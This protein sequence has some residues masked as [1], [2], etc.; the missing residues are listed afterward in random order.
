MNAK[1]N[2]LDKSPKDRVVNFGGHTQP[3]R[4]KFAWAST[5]KPGVF[6][7]VPKAD[8]NIDGRYQREEV[9]S[10]KTMEI[11]RSWDWTLFGTLLVGERGDGSLWVYDGGHRTRASFYRD[12]I[13]DLPCMVFRIEDAA[14]EAK[15]FYG[16]QKLKSNI[17]V[18]DA[19]RA[20]V[21]AQEPDALRVQALLDRHG[22]VIRRDANRGGQFRAIG[23]L[24]GIAREDQELAERVLALCVD[25]AGD[26]SPIS[27]SVLGGMFA[28]VQHFAGTVDFF[29]G[30]ELEA[31]L[32]T[33]IEEL[34]SEIRR[35]K[36][37]LGMGGTVSEAKGILALVNKSRR[38]KIHW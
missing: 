9:S 17:S 26:D 7:W 2:I 1:H 33:S 20:G 24:R 14:G 3:K 34:D 30:R 31:L 5:S 35:Q 16:A 4:E 36:A 38:K 28:L 25:I 6:R 11:A 27:G 19:H 8:L 37:I 12:D 15:A 21:I 18:T 13:P 32:A 22:L 23:T 29:A 10:A